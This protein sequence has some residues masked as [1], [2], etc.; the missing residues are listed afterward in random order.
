MKKC[1]ICN[2]N[3]I[4]GNWIDFFPKILDAGNKTI[5]DF[6]ELKP[7]LEGCI[8]ISC[9]YFII[10]SSD[11]VYQTENLNLCFKGGEKLKTGYWS[12]FLPLFKKSE[13][14]GFLVLNRIG[15][16]TKITSRYCPNH[17]IFFNKNSEFEVIDN[18]DTEEEVKKYFTLKSNKHNLFTK[19]VKRGAIIL[20]FA[21][22]GLSLIIFLLKPTEISTFEKAV[23]L[24]VIG[25]SFMSIG[26]LI[27]AFIGM[28]CFKL[29]L[30]SISHT[31]YGKTGGAGEKRSKND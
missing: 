7:P 29:K 9:N 18:V 14:N 25:T 24:F 13:G 10:G 22:L 26:M 2:K 4:I 28:I 23:A 15:T 17:M 11:L 8:C 20:G 27:G 5:R 3:L 1:P 19:Y 6:K 30:F 16:N 31:P 21:S 12:G